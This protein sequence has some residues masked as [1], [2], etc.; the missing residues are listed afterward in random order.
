[1]Y[2]N[3]WNQENREKPRRM[4]SLPES[5]SCDW[6]RDV[7][8]F[9]RSWRRRK[10]WKRRRRRRPTTETHLPMA[11]WVGR[12]ELASWPFVLAALIMQVSLQPPPPPVQLLLTR[13][14]VWVVKRHRCFS[15][16]SLW[17]FFFRWCPPTKSSLVDNPSGE[18]TRTPKHDAFEC[19]WRALENL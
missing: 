1:M 10:K 2:F 8:L 9:C 11:Q 13:R 7:L 3:S 15:F 17:T 5:L 18:E 16:A 14:F 4:N 6:S 12:R 19:P